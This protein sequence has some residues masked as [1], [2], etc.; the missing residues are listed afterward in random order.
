MSARNRMKRLRGKYQIMKNT[1]VTCYLDVVQASEEG[2]KAFIGLSSRGGTVVPVGTRIFFRAEPSRQ[3][4]PQPSH[5]FELYSITVRQI[6]DVNGQPILVCSPIQKES[7]PDLR[8][9]ARKKV[10]FPVTLSGK[11]QGASFIAKEGTVNGLTLVYTA[12]K[13]LLSLVLG[14]VYPFTVEYKGTA[15]HLPG[16]VKHIQYDWK[17]H[18]HLVGVHFRQLPEQEKIILNLLLDPN[19]TIPIMD[20]QTVDTA[21]GKISGVDE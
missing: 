13:A 17:T 16:E 18:E 21:L 2:F 1:F 9:E 14:Q 12:K 8:T 20:R 15:Y 3:A 6:E 10:Q 5:A 4:E 19:Y 11:N 7:R